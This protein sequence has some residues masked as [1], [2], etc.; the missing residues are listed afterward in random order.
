MKRLAGVLCCVLL[1]VSGCAA[2]QTGPSGRYVAA[3][4]ADNGAEHIAEIAFG[5]ETLLMKT[6]VTEQ[7]VPYRIENDTLSLE[8]DFGTFS[9]AFSMEQD[10][11]YIDGEQYIR[12]EESP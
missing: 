3:L 7:E 9:F 4:P 12:A 8:T 6:G 2:K 1:I 11:V 5:P 10:W